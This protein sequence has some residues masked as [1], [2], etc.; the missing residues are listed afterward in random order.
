[1]LQASLQKT[2]F[3]RLA[4]DFPLQ[5][6]HLAFLSATLAVSGKRLS[7]A[8]RAAHGAN[9]ECLSCLQKRI[10]KRQSPGTFAP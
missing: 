3:H 1:M 7:T 8:N 9:G 2:D 10:S 5:T 6:G 4:T